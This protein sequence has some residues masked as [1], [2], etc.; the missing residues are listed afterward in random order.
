M[1]ALPTASR[2]ARWGTSA[3]H[4]ETLGH[5]DADRDSVGFRHRVEGSLD[6]PSEQQRN[7]ISCIG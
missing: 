7:P 6:L 3:Q 4:Q 2:G 1:M 5:V